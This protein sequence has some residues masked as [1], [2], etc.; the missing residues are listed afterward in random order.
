MY[1]DYLIRQARLAPEQIGL[2]EKVQ[3]GS[4][5]RTNYEYINGMGIV[6]AGQD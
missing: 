4:P 5:S 1:S 2:L 6:Q 3:K